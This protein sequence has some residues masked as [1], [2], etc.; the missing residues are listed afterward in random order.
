MTHAQ[1]TATARTWLGT[2]FHHQGRLKMTR[3]HRG[4]VDCLGLLVGI[5]AE[6]DLRGRDRV[7]LASLDMTQYGHYPDEQRLRAALD[8]AL[9]AKEGLTPGEGDVALLEV[10]GRAQHLGLITRYPLS[11]GAA[12]LGLLHAYAPARGV[13]EHALDASWKARVI[14]LWRLEAST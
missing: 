3:E 5:A 4:G 6:L 12:T 8:D 10:D 1:L 11:G 14:G 2:K 13:V 9:W 7:R